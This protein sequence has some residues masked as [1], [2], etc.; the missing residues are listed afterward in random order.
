VA[1][2][3]AVAAAHDDGA[4]VMSICAGAFVLAEAGVLDG[5]RAFRQR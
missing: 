5:R 1:A 2:A 4:R 3:A